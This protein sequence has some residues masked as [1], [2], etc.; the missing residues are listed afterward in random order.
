MP[1]AGHGEAEVVQSRHVVRLDA[2]GFAQ[3]GDGLRI[4]LLL[5]MNLSQV[6]AGADIARVDLLNA[7]ELANGIGGPVR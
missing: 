1:A 4:L 6:D 2:R 7:L 5:E 3:G